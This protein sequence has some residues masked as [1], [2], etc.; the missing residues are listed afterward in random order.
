[1]AQ[2]LSPAR[3]AA[4]IEVAL[5]ISLGFDTDVFILGGGPAGLAT[6]IAAR[7]EGF[8]VILADAQCPPIDKACG[9]GLMPD[10][11][12]AAA[13]LGID[14]P[15]EGH[16]FKGIRFSGP[17]N[18]VA[19]EFSHGTGLGVRRT[20]LHE[21]LVRHAEREG[22]E[23]K[24][25]SPVRGIQD[26]NV[27]LAQQT[28]TARWIVGDDGMRSSVRRWAGLDHVKSERIRY[29][30]RRHYRIAPWSE[31]VE[32]HWAEG[33]QLYITPVSAAEICVVVMSRDSQFRLDQ[34]LSL[35][36]DVKARL[37]K[38][39]PATVERGALAATQRLKRVI[40]GNI[41]LVGDASGT[42]DPITGKGVYLGFQQA[43]A[44]AAAL[45]SGDLAQYQHAHR[46]IARRPMFMADLML[47]MDRWPGIRA[48]ALVALEA[49]PHLFADLLAIHEGG[50][51]TGKIAATAAMLGWEVATA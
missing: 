31:F 32:I 42:V 14:V 21:W 11:L 50:L 29:S 44:L 18:S 28:M 46:Q 34:A 4:K 37:D 39:E 19:A 7:R 2:D 47:L 9:E 48:R 6:A 1:L 13:R 35:F 8:R 12:A 41:A 5:E 22:V 10:S 3:G 30:F 20:F 38:C 49:H 51:G 40:R 24:W 27:R 36:P 26:T 23:L 43:A 15:S 25:N 16:P 45:R 33:C 17:T